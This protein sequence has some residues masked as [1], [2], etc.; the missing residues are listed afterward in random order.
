MDFVLED[1]RGLQR[2]LDPGDRAKLDQ[3][4]TGGREV[5]T[6]IEK[7][8]RFGEAPDPDVPTPAGIPADYAEYIQLMYDMLL[9]AFQTDSTRVATLLLA[10]DG[11][12]RSFDHIGISDGHHDLSHHFDDPVKIKKVQQIDHW[13]VEQLAKFLQKLEATKD[14]DGNSLLHNSMIVYG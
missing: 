3:Y 12:N 1:A 9:I 5:E 14:I 6:R 4:L 2:K 7:T 8:E 10:H 11:S 13:Y